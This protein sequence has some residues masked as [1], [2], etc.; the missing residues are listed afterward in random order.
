ML[1]PV[2]LLASLLLFTPS[3]KAEAPVVS[4]ARLHQTVAGQRTAIA[5]FTVTNQ[6]ATPDRLLMVWFNVS[7]EAHIVRVSG[8]GVINKGLYL[9]PRG[10]IT[11]TPDTTAVLLARLRESI[12]PEMQPYEAVLTFEHAGQVRA[13]FTVVRN[14]PHRP[15]MR[16]KPI[17][18]I[19]C[20]RAI[21]LSSPQ[22]ASLAQARACASNQ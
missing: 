2:A 9:P 1:K 21:R 22:T 20:A 4:H 8:L 5:T 10:R 17:H 11:L 19:N 13:K 18:K 15:L 3:A 7:R 12:I 14:R 6:S 16:T